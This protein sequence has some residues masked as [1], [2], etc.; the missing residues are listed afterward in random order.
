MSRTGASHT[1]PGGPLRAKASPDPAMSAA[2]ASD[3][4]SPAK[5]RAGGLFQREN[6]ANP[7]ASAKAQSEIYVMYDD[8][9]VLVQFMNHVP[10]G[11]NV[12]YMDGHVEFIKYPGEMPFAKLY[13]L[14]TLKPPIPLA[15]FEMHMLWHRRTDEAVAHAWL[16]EVV[17][18]VCRK[19]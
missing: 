16:R 13:P 3:P 11:G 1:A 5:S 15:P 14:R 9:N 18:G 12:L 17:K 7:A 6:P 4:A 8:V 19:L 2:A 10:G